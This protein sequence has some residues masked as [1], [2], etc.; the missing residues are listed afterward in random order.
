MTCQ[1]L[2]EKGLSDG[3][4]AP[5]VPSEGTY[6]CSLVSRLSCGFTVW[7]SICGA[8]SAVCNSTRLLVAWCLS[9]CYCLCWCWLPGTWNIYLLPFEESNANVPCPGFDFDHIL[10]LSPAWFSSSCISAFLTN[11]K[12][13]QSLRYHLEFLIL[14]ELFAEHTLM[15]WRRGH[16]EL[17][18]S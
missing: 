5:P 11:A 1:Q 7:A 14:T 9:F 2:S 6:L 18:L 10:N 12:H 16:M 17:S 13:K 8:V 15:P 4:W 3:L